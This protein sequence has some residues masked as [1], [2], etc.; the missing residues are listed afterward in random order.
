MDRF[1]V[2]QSYFAWYLGHLNADGTISRYCYYADGSTALA[3]SYPDSDDSYAAT[4]LA[5]VCLVLPHFYGD[6]GAVP[7]V[8][9]QMGAWWGIVL[10]FGVNA[11]ATLVQYGSGRDD[12][13]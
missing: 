5:A 10:V 13:S 2:A 8:V 11:L 7:M 1:A 3:P 6:R 4:F 12:A 9:V